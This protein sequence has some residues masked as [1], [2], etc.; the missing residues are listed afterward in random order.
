[1][2]LRVVAAPLV[3]ARGVA[4]A[5]LR[6]HLLLLLLEGALE[7]AAAAVRLQHSS[8]PWKGSCSG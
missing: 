7:G 6:W 3:G 8:Q 2:A 1:V 4:A 5:Q